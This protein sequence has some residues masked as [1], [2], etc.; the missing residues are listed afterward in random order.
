MKKFASLLI[1]LALVLTSVSALGAA[2]PSKTGS[3]IAKVVSLTDGVWIKVVE[4]D[5]KAQAE[6]VRMRNAFIS[7]T[8]VSG[9]FNTQV[10]SEIAGAKDVLDVIAVKCGGNTTEETVSFRVWGSTPYSKAVCV[11]GIYDSALNL[12]YYVTLPTECQA[13]GSAIITMTQAQ[14]EAVKAAKSTVLAFVQM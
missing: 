5:F 13:D 4:P 10:A 6:V 1:A 7:G 11:M 9:L 12:Y 14:F 8:P 2:V 3:S